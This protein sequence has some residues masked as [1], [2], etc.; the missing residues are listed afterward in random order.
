MAAGIGYATVLNL[1]YV[2]TTLADPGSTGLRIA[3]FTL[4]QALLTGLS[5]TIRGGLIV[6]NPVD[7]KG[8]P[9]STGNAAFQGIGA[10]IFLVVVLFSAFYF[11]INNADER[12]RLRNRPESLR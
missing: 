3:D 5:I 11:L 9:S 8:V 12:A 2:F 10:A 6:G 4:S 1:N 7:S